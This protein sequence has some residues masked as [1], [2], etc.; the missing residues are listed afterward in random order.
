MPAPGTVWAADTWDA[1][2]WAADTWAEADSTPAVVG[3]YPMWQS[4]VIQ[5]TAVDFWILWVI[6]P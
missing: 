3:Y 2:A 5:A 1:D 4:S 6:C